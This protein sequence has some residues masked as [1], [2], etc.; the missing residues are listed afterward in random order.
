VKYITV[1]HRLKIAG[2][3]EGE[4]EI[5]WVETGFCNFVGGRSFRTRKF[6]RGGF[7]NGLNYFCHVVS[8]MITLSFV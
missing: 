5:I 4:A 7:Y 2:M 1:F 3:G 6:V 8:L